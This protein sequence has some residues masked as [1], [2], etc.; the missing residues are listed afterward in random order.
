MSDPAADGFE[1]LDET[2]VYRGFIWSAVN[3]RFRGPDG[4]EF[5]R[6]IIRSRGAVGVLPMSAEHDRDPLVTLVNQ[7]RP[8]LE[9]AIVEIPAGIRDVPG[10]PVEL[11]ARREL[12]E[13]V[14]YEADELHPLG[15]IYPSAG[16]T[17]SVTWIFLATGLRRVERCTHGPEEAAMTVT[18]MR[19]SEAL[20][21][22]EAGAI[23]D[24]KT[25]VALLRAARWL[26][27]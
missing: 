25:V 17:D 1:R 19:L 2:L 5:E 14:G 22:V 8:P 16:M 10:E 21:A 7:Y 13:E 20:A 4:A 24:A 3:A 9:R 18:E 11:T 26:N 12:I 6:D 15:R 27:R 23:E